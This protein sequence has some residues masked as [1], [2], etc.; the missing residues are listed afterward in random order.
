MPSICA[1][2]LR[3]F[4]DTNALVEHMKRAHEMDPD[5]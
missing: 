5:A 2:C 3:R 4:R 1:I